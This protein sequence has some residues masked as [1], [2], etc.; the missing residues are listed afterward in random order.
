MMLAISS[1][2]GS[3]NGPIYNLILYEKHKILKI[4]L[5][6]LSE[7]HEKKMNTTRRCSNT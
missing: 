6:R 2:V 7:I 1:I 3:L 4:S 5:A